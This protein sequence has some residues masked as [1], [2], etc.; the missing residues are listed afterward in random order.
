[1]HDRGESR[2]VRGMSETQEVGYGPNASLAMYTLQVSV[3]DE[4]AVAAM[5]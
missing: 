4:S 5:L 1:M 3:T 2:A